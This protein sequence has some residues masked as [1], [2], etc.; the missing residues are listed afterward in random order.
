MSTTQSLRS[1]SKDYFLLLVWPAA[2]I[3]AMIAN[4]AAGG[5]LAFIQMALSVGLIVHTWHLW[6]RTIVITPDQICYNNGF[7][8]G[9]IAR[10]DVSVCTF[11][12]FRKGYRRGAY[13][14]LA[15]KD[16]G[17]TVH[18]PLYFL[19]EAALRNWLNGLSVAPVLEKKLAR[20]AK[21]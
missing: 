7:I 20:Y 19:R 5:K 9:Q 8:P 2:M 18:I 17:T 11:T 15:P 3:I 13:L 4:T 12:R 1:Q 21:A 16:K 14:T 10:N 6:K